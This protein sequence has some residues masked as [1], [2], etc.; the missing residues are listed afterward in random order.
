MFSEH[1]AEAVKAYR[2]F[3]NEGI[4]E[5][6]N[7]ILGSRK[8]PPVIGK[9]SFIDWVKNSFFLKK[10]HIE[11]PESKMLAPDARKIWGVVC[12]LYNVNEEDLLVSRRGTTNEPRDVAIYLTKKLT[13]STLQEIGREFGINNY[14]SVSTVI[15]R[16]KKKADTER[17]FRKRIEKL[18]MDLMV[19][20]KQT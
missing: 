18:E 14:S 6:I 11:V 13:G 19:S 20:Q 7:R 1:K 12:R 2:N 15:E 3:V 16:T 17:A 9:E 10:R 5:E 4:P 8:W